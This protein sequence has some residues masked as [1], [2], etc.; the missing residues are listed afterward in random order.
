M[1]ALRLSTIACSADFI[2]K[3]P[4]SVALADVLIHRHSQSHRHSES[5]FLSSFP[6]ISHYKTFLKCYVGFNRIPGIRFTKMF[7]LNQIYYSKIL[8]WHFEMIFFLLLH[9]ANLYSVCIPKIIFSVAVS[10]ITVCPFNT[11]LFHEEKCLTSLRFS[12]DA[13][14]ATHIPIIYIFCVS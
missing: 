6:F 1:A 9:L 10:S 14:S 8:I 7:L 11:F 12:K 4:L 13:L 3:G 5:M 2:S